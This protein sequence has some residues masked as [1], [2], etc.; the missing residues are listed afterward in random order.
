MVVVV[1]FKY[2]RGAIWDGENPTHVQIV[3]IKRTQKHIP[4]H[5]AWVKTVHSLRG[6]NT[7]PTTENQTQNSI[8]KIVRCSIKRNNI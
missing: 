4:L 2:D 6:Q 1:D 7:G 3:P 8:K 5:I